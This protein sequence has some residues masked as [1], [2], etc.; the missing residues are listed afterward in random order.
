MAWCIQLN[1]YYWPQLLRGKHLTCI[2]HVNTWQRMNDHCFYCS[3]AL[4]SVHNFIM[5]SWVLIAY[6]KISYSPSLLSS[7]PFI[8]SKSFSSRSSF[9]VIRWLARAHTHTYTHT[10]THT[11][12]HTQRKHFAS[13]ELNI[14]WEEVKKNSVFLC[15]EGTHVWC[16]SPLEPPW[17]CTRVSAIWVWGV[18]VCYKYILTIPALHGRVCV[19]VCVIVHLCLHMYVCDLNSPGWTTREC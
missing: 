6:F 16:R 3:A 17:L 13:T 14:P 2:L 9:T 5:P 15:V 12:T 4:S 19:C 11:H 18:S 10:H 7:L 8:S 1:W